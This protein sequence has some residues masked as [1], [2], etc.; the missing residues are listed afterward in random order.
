[1]SL[2][3]THDSER[4]LREISVTGNLIMSN[5]SVKRTLSGILRLTKEDVRGC[6]FH[7]RAYTVIFSCNI[8]LMVQH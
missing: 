2:S 5:I 7:G 3:M 6:Y 8:L 4:H 1:M